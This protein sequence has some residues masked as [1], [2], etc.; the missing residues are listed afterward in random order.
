MP[1]YWYP[2]EGAVIRGELIKADIIANLIQLAA[3]LHEILIVLSLSAIALSIFRR[4][5]VG[6]GVRLGFLTGGYRVGDLPY[7]WSAAFRHQGLDKSRPWEL[8]HCNSAFE[9]ITLPLICYNE[10]V[11]V[12]TV[13][14]RDY[15]NGYT[16]RTKLGTCDIL[17][18]SK[19]P[20]SG[21][22][23]L[24]GWAENLGATDLANNLIFQSESTKIRRYLNITKKGDRMLS[25]TPP[26]FLMNSIGLFQQFINTTS[27][28]AVSKEPRYQLTSKGDN[29]YQ[30]FVQSI[31]ETHPYTNSSPYLSFKYPVGLECF[32]DADCEHTKSHPP[33]L[34]D[35]WPNATSWSS[36]S[37]NPEYT[38]HH[39]NSSVV[40]TSGLVSNNNMD[41]E[42][43]LCTMLASWAGSTFT[44]TPQ[45]DDILRARPSAGNDL[46]EAYH[47]R[48]DGNIRVI[49][50]ERDWFPISNPELK[51]SNDHLSNTTVGR[52]IQQLRYNE[53]K[54]GTSADH[55]DPLGHSDTPPNISLAK[56]FGAYLTESLSRSSLGSGPFVR[57]VETDKELSLVD[58]T[59]QHGYFRDIRTYKR[60]NETHSNVTAQ[61]ITYYPERT[62]ENYTATFKQALNI[63][64]QAK[65]YGYGSGQR[66]RTLD[67]AVSMMCIYLGTVFTYGLVI[68]VL[69]VLELLQIHLWGGPVRVLSV[70]PWSDLQDLFLL[71]LRTPNPNDQDS[72]DVG[73]GVTSD[74]IWKKIV[75]VRADHADNVQLAL[76]QNPDDTSKVETVGGKKYY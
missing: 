2:E 3:K 16:Y 60:L 41:R 20:A 25:T 75:R 10:S 30:P 27:V 73:A 13:H 69:S 48:F 65:R 35:V 54:N 46:Q 6:G 56:V 4:R 28:G 32:G 23:E 68:A 40:F 19:Y 76:D 51:F 9:N 42:L 43:Y 17:D 8:V 63:D 52:L 70:A 64:M 50:F 29:Q 57:L 61:G 55:I 18:S 47:K 62:F 37:L 53:T 7:L 12:W 39:D 59:N 5:L 34:A 26:H 21:Y 14:L 67:F 11:E 1:V 15:N 44:Y 36:N 45:V 72:A 58:L 31:C 38:T 71:A 49:K 22:S 24:M 66:R 33:S 74:Q